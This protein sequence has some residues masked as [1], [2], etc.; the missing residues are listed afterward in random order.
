MQPK[1]F[2]GFTLIEIIIVLGILS[3]VL[4][5]IIPRFGSSSDMINL[6]TNTEKIFSFFNVIQLESVNTRQDILV[7]LNYN[8]Q[9]NFIDSIE[10]NSSSSSTITENELYSEKEYISPGIIVSTN[11]E[12]THILFKSNR[13]FN[14][15]NDDLEI[16]NEDLN[17]SFSTQSNQRSIIFYSNSGK[18]IFN[19]QQ[20]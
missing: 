12:I 15:F 14:Y 18:I 7:S 5:T 2:R 13:T 3:V 11:F 20:N 6:D 4:F 10:Y 8:T 19:E 17:L 9:T 16:L 1:F